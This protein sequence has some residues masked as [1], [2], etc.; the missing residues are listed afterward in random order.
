MY[1]T[2]GAFVDKK[3]R[4]SLSQLKL[5][6]KILQS[7]GFQVENYLDA[8]GG[9]DPYIFCYNPSK[10]GS[11]DGIRIY[12]IGD[13][14]AFRVQKENKTHPYGR[15]YSISIEQM[16]NDFLEDEKTSEESAGKKVIEAVSREIKRF[17]EKSGEIERDFDKSS[18]SDGI[19]VRQ[20][21]TDY[22]NLIFNKS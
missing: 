9:E 22:S 15:A 18:D 19:V 12:S 1:K 21:G 2:F 8:E 20:T 16:F 14:I 6:E 3:K 5:V 13:T 17:F 4:E 10:E 11:F 7:K